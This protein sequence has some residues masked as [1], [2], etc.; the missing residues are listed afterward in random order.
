[1]PNE[2]KNK[3][4]T[5]EGFDDISNDE[6]EMIARTIESN[7]DLNFDFCFEDSKDEENE[8][9]IEEREIFTKIPDGETLA[10]LLEEEGMWNQESKE[11]RIVKTWCNDA[12][13]DLLSSEDA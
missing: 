12:L 4:Q 8:L 5:Y 9:T 2:K 7:L 3:V 6:V 10:D 13:D 1:L 11:V